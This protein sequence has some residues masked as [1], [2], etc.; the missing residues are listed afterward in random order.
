MSD[1]VRSPGSP[2]STE[3]EQHATEPGSDRRTCSELTSSTANSCGGHLPGDDSVELEELLRLA[4]TGNRLALQQIDRLNVH[5]T[6]INNDREELIRSLRE[7]VKTAKAKRAACREALD[8][9][10]SDNT[11]LVQRLQDRVN[12]CRSHETKWR[13]L[14]LQVN[15]L[16]AEV[17][18]HRHMRNEAVFK[19]HWAMANL[20]S[21]RHEAEHLLRLLHND[22]L[23]YE[24]RLVT[25]TNR[26]NCFK[27]AGDPSVDDSELFS[28]DDFEL[29][30]RVQEWATKGYKGKGMGRK[31][32]GDR[33]VIRWHDPNQSG[34]GK[35]PG[36]SVWLA[37]PFKAPS[38]VH[39]KGDVGAKGCAPS[40]SS[41]AP[42][43]HRAKA[44]ASP[45]APQGAP[46]TSQQTLLPVKASAN[47]PAARIPEHPN[48]A[49]K[50]P[51]SVPVTADPA[52]AVLT[53]PNPWE[54]A[55]ADELSTT[56]NTA[57]S[58]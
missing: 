20:D 56:P 41:F 13:L 21:F 40:S 26:V 35:G 15:E 18:Q 37:P 53:V 19:E 55:F 23:I 51:M 46:H 25:M 5:F 48:A 43:V 57:R 4:N 54:Q 7:E 30:P 33:F 3:H 8:E 42:V 10:I 52:S 34:K 36:E 58:V 11:M 44:P 38:L 27:D 6:K 14:E 12:D 22:T 2:A 16:Q 31:G 17:E 47:I 49:P 9:A 45:P 29:D 1:E 24:R 39:Y 32:N 50:A 28:G